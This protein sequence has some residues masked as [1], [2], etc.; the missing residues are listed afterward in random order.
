MNDLLLFS[1]LVNYYDEM[2]STKINKL[3]TKPTSLFLTKVISHVHFWTRF[4]LLI[5][6]IYFTWFGRINIG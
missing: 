2:K 4:E 5:E 3:P 6:M 1:V